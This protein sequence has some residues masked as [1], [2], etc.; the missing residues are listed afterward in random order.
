M[1]DDLLR[2]AINTQYPGLLDGTNLHGFD[3]T[4]AVNARKRLDEIA[5]VMKESFNES[6]KVF[7]SNDVYHFI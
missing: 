2:E 5:A 6:E 4:E 1:Y 3:S 7:V